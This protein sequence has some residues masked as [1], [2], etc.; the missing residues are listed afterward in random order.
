MKFHLNISVPPSAFTLQHQAPI[1]MIGSCFSEQIYHKL[2]D[3]KFNVHSNPFGIVFNP[4]SIANQLTRIV[5]KHYFTKNE[6]IEKQQQYVCLDTHSQFTASNPTLLLDQL[7]H[8]IVVWHQHLCK[9]HTLFITFGSAFAYAKKD[10]QQVVA[11]CHKI[12]QSYFNKQLLTTSSLVAQFHALYEL[13]LALNPTLQIVLTVSPVKHLKDGVVEN[14]LSKSI[15]IQTSH[16][17]VNDLAH[18]SYFPSYELVTDD[19]RDYRFYE[20]DLAHP[21]ALAVDYV[22]QKFAECYFNNHTT[23]LN[24]R[25]MQIHQA[26][27]HKLFNE[28]STESIQFKKDNLQ[29]CLA[30]KEEFPFLNLQSEIIYFKSA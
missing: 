1:L 14:N 15:L 19:L 20:K 21:N 25:L 11:N 24:Q 17:L 18:C 22:W 5:N 12:P 30:L 6:V 10:T 26:Y 2:H 28:H 8:Q 9:A 23:Q 7:N 4:E 29:K 3:L 27:L 13:L 16:Q